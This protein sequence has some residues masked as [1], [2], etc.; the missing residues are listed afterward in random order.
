MPYP[1][2]KGLSMTAFWNGREF[3]FTT[4]WTEWL[5]VGYS[6]EYSRGAILGDVHCGNNYGTFMVAFK[7]KIAYAR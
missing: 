5:V 6:R 2:E 4:E 1:S 7:K 3:F